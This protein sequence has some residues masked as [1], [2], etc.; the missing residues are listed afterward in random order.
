[1]DHTASELLLFL[2]LGWPVIAPFSGVLPS[3]TGIGPR[4][5][6]GSVSNISARLSEPFLPARKQPVSWRMATVEE[7]RTQSSPFWA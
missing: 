1:M 7:R 5:A 3:L 2:V 4:K 6:A